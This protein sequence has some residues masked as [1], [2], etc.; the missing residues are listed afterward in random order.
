MLCARATFAN[1]EQF[2]HSECHQQPFRLTAPSYLSSRT[3]HRILD[4]EP[5]LARLRIFFNAG[6][7]V[8]MFVDS[9]L[10]RRSHPV[11]ARAFR[12]PSLHRLRSVV[13]SELLHDQ[14][15]HPNIS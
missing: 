4:V 13:A 8:S 1:A 3:F 9:G 12:M 10:L 5:K 6:L 7:R 2:F 15:H 11:G 14:F